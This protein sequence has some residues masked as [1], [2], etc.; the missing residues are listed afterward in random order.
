MGNM[1]DEKFL[2]SI[3]EEEIRDALKGNSCAPAKIG[4]KYFEFEEIEFFAERF[5]IYIPKDNV[6]KGDLRVK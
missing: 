5:K 1:V 6:V 2:N 4:E 3:N